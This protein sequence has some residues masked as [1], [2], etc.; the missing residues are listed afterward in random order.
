RRQTVADDGRRRAPPSGRGGRARLSRPVRT[1]PDVPAVAYKAL[2]AALHRVRVDAPAGSV[3]AP[4]WRAG[5][6]GATKDM[7]DTGATERNKGSKE[8]ARR[9]HESRS[10]PG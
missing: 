2:H 6:R 3:T 1:R 9:P 7:R 10:V 8:E 4:G 5:E